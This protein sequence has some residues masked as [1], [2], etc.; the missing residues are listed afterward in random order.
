[1]REELRTKLGFRMHIYDGW[2]GQI[3]APGTRPSSTE[4]GLEFYTEATQSD[5]HKLR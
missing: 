2:T 1:M 3:V 4:R 5:E